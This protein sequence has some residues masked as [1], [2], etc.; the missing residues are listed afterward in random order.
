MYRFDRSVSEWLVSR[1]P[2]RCSVHGNL[3]P[4]LDDTP[5]H[6]PICN[7][8]L[9]TI[10]CFRARTSAFEFKVTSVLVLLHNCLG[11]PCWYLFRGNCNIY[12]SYS[13]ERGSVL[14]QQRPLSLSALSPISVGGDII[15]VVALME[16]PRKW[17]KTKWRE[18]WEK[19]EVW[20]G[21]IFKT[22]HCQT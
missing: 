13:I 15:T 8:C 4:L 2:S 17:A 5:R 21:V 1:S 22:S 3:C 6:L 7:G 16:K 12:A 20:D 9:S 18:R 14:G 10:M 19:V 11:S